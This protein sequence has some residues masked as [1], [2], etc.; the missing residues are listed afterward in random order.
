MH[1]GR[2][3]LLFDIGGGSTELAWV[4]LG[5]PAPELIGYDSLPI[6]VVSL[7]ER[8]GPVGF[9][10]DGFQA[11]V[12]DVKARLLPFERVHCIGHETR[13]GGIRLL[14]TSGTV[15][16]LAGRRPQPGPLSPPARWTAR[17]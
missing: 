3:A 2:R 6:G 1:A 7:A 13:M 5:G 10:P 16:T 11:M 4:R 9:E 14:G 12:D 15:T 17:C 8:F